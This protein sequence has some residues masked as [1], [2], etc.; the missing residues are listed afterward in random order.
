MVAAR[1]RDEMRAVGLDVEVVDVAPGRPNVV[2]VLDASAS[3]HTLLL[4]GHLD[5]VGVA[6][7]AAPFT[8]VER[9]GRVFGRG[10]QDMKGGI[11]AMIGAAAVIAARGLRGGR[12][13][14]ATVAD[15]EYAS[16]G[17]DAL[18]STWRADGAVVAEPTDLAVAIGHKGFSWLEVDTIGHAA[19][20]SRPAEGRDAILDMGRVLGR[21]AAID[22]ELRVRAPHPLLGTAS[23]HA[24]MITGG[25]ELSV[26]PDHCRLALERR[27]LVDEPDGIA[28]TEVEE[29]LRVLS[30]DDGALQASA[31][32]LFERPAY[33]IAPDHP[34]PQA[35]ARIL[36]GARLPSAFVGMSF[37]TDAAVLA[38]ANMP[39]VLFGPT[40]G[41]LHGRDEYV[42]VDSVLTCRDVLANLADNY[43]PEPKAN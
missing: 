24:S 11:A 32:V 18:V 22:T 7:M 31:R 23:L 26:Y 41:G 6:G 34:L 8:P 27:T 42:T 13:I 43:C 12:L 35:L 28:L 2:G 15:E 39:S 1:V 10:S 19:H 38:R 16:L 4:C 3:G 40:G 14:V 30:A 29:V 9:N 36:T 17:A 37:W 33:E 5:T 25:R 21:L 20:G